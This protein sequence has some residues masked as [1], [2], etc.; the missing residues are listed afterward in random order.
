MAVLFGLMMVIGVGTIFGVR[1]IVDQVGTIRDFSSPLA[2]SSMNLLYWTEKSLDTFT[3]AALGSRKDLLKNL[4]DIEVSLDKEMAK[5]ET[6]VSGIPSLLNKLAGIRTMYKKT[7]DRGLEWVQ[8][9]LDEDWLVEPESAM[10]FKRARGE[11]VKAII[12]LKTN[13]VDELSASLTKISRVAQIATLRTTLTCLAGLIVFIFLAMLLSKTIVKP[14]YWIIDRLRD[15]AEQVSSS[16]GHVSSENQQVSDGATKQAASIE[17]TSSSLEEMSSMTKMNSENAN[18]ANNL[19]IQTNQVVNKA[20]ESMGQLTLSMEEISKASEETSKIIKTIDEIAFQTNLLALN[21][22]VE[23]ARAGEAGAG[24]AVVA[25]EVRNL[26]MR[27][28]DAAKNTAD[29]IEEIVKKIN[30]GGEIVTATNQAFGD[31]TDSSAKVKDLVG[32]IAAASDE[33]AQGIEQVNRA[34][35]EMDVVVQQNASSAEETASA[36]EEMSAQAEQMAGIVNALVSLI[37]GG[38]KKAGNGKTGKAIRVANGKQFT[39]LREE[40]VETK[41]T[42]GR[43]REVLKVSEVR[44]EEVIP[45]DDEAFKGNGVTS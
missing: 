13:G 35:S 14:I 38:K 10:A 22:A 43:R 39:V 33:L 11:L 31:V 2:V 21:A 5:T 6:L 20:N 40:N 4:K 12:D 25:D 3:V 27:A 32:K 42:E 37:E 24:F 19:M 18:E 41:K 23:A 16:S 36:S 15:I 34:V 29:L 9:T 7:R 30:G 26:A 28:A 1:N 45:M 44:P 8:V 17:E